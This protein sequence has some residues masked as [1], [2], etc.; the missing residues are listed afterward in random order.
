M[1]DHGNLWEASL[2]NARGVAQ[3]LGALK[4]AGTVPTF[5]V[6]VEESNK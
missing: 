4:T 2:L 1:G 6:V 3:R 5:L